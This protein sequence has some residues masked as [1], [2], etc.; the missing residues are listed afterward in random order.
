MNEQEAKEELEKMRT[1]EKEELLVTK[2]HFLSFREV[3]VAQDDF[4]AFRG[5]A[6]HY[7]KV[8]YTYEPGW[9]K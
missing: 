2:E 9:T 3:L 6:G 7:G 5:R 8:I 4:Q 1:G